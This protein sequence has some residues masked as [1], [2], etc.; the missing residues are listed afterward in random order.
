MK[1]V[2]R[3][4]TLLNT[5][6]AWKAGAVPKYIQQIVQFGRDGLTWDAG[7]RAFV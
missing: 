3:G 2:L 5:R 1:W 4:T 7:R 6:P